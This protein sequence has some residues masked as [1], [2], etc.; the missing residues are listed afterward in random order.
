MLISTNTIG[1][2]VN[3]P[4]KTMIVRSLEI[5]TRVRKNVSIRDF[6]NIAGRAGRAGKETEGQ[7]IFLAFDKKNESLFKKYTD[8]ANIEQTKSLLLLLLKYLVEERIPSSKFEKY[9]EYYFEPSLLNLL[10]EETVDT[11]DE[12]FIKEI[13][14]YSLFIIQSEKEGYDIAPLVEGMLTIGRKFYSK[15]EDNDLRKVYS[16]TGF[17]L[18][19][20]N[21]LSEFIESNSDELKEIIDNDDYESLLRKSLDVFY[22]IDEMKEEKLDSTILKENNG[23][24]GDFVMKWIKGAPVSE[25][26]TLWEN[27]FSET[28]LK[29]EMQLYINQILNYRCLG[30]L[31]SSY[32]F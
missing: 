20:C 25:L 19:S 13:L 29:D 12:K 30:A 3:F 22:E 24:L 1:Q 5:D 15:V 28:S 21:K 7:I 26:K 31:L 11:L 18:S 14:G 32:L 23:A 16:K 10:V 6:W 2:G 17:H 4:I 8:K 27:S 9:L